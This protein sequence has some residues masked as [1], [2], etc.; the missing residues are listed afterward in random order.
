[1]QGGGRRGETRVHATVELCSSL[2]ESYARVVHQSKFNQITDQS[3]FDVDIH[4]NLRC[5]ESQR[6]QNRG[7]LP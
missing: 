5:H 6:G 7:L 1:V 2:V 4:N 3:K